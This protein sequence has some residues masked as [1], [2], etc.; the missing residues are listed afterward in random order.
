L[1]IVFILLILPIAIKSELK[2]LK[3]TNLGT[4]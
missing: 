3:P 4:A 2:I 1:E